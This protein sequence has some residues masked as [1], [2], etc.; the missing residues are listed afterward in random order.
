MIYLGCVTSERLEQFND[1]RELEDKYPLIFFGVV[2]EAEVQLGHK[3]DVAEL[4]ELFRIW[5]DSDSLSL[6]EGVQSFVRWYDDSR[7]SME[8][9]VDE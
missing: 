2:S 3:F 8:A 5:I 7:N 9:Q 6:D 1:Y 4:F